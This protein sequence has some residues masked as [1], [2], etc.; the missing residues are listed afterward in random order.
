MRVVFS[1]ALGEA[2]Y[3]LHPTAVGGASGLLTV[4]QGCLTV[5]QNT[6]QE[7]RWHEQGAVLEGA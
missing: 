2:R 6:G 4:L 7:G 5:A 1:V 3:P